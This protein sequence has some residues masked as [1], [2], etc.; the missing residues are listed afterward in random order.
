VLLAAPMMGTSS[1]MTGP[2]LAGLLVGLGGIL[3]IFAPWQASG[4]LSW[5]AL[6]CLA[7]A[8]SYGFAFVY[9][10]KYLSGT[11]LSPYA[12]SAG[13]MLVASGFLV[14]A[15]PAGGFTPV[16]FQLGPL[17]AILVLG[18]GSTG[19]AFALNYQ[20]LASEGAVAASVVG[21]LLPVVSVLLGAVFLGEQLNAR[22]IAGMVVVLGGVALTR[23]RKAAVT[24][25]AAPLVDERV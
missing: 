22:V 4:L 25:P 18:I 17:L 14:L 11:S 7:A 21:Y 9:E 12:L 15:L 5:G 24:A 20:L 3:L 13:Q 2:R 10:G 8:A 6:A 1:R 19:F 16:H 23:L